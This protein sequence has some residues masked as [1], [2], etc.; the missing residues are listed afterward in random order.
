MWLSDTPDYD[1][2]LDCLLCTPG[3]TGRLG[4]GRLVAGMFQRSD[5][6]R[7]VA[8]VKPSYSYSY[9]VQADW[10]TDWLTGVIS[11]PHLQTGS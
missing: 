11:K 10:L 4:G 9:S 8:L 6:R 3:L 1:I 7:E 5:W 2:A